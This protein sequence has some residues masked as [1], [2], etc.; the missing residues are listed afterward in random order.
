VLLALAAAAGPSPARRR[1]RW[2]GSCSGCC[3]TS[4]SARRSARRRSR[5][6]RRLRRRLRDVD[7]RPPSGGWRRCSPAS[8]RAV[9]EAVVPLIREFIGESHPFEPRYG[10]VVGVVGDRRRGDE[11]VL[12]PIGAGACASRS[13]SGR[14]REKLV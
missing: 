3:T 4:T 12:V 14:P 2:P 13:R 10:V 11:P 8:G 6:A 5:W 9:G 7:H 1:A